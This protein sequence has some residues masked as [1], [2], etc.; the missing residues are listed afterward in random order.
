MNM[1]FLTVF[2]ADLCWLVVLIVKLCQEGEKPQ[3]ER[4][5]L[6]NCFVFLTVVC[7]T[8]GVVVGYK[9]FT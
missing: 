1:L 5:N 4:S 8:V 9:L 7:V 3:E 6:Y 2:T